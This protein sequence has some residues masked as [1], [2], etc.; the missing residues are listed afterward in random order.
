[1]K[2][3]RYALEALLLWLLFFVFRLMPV[4]SASALGGSIGRVIGPR[5]AASRK[6]SR[7]LQQCIPTLSPAEHD[8]VISG[9]WDNLG[10]VI[11]EYPH[12][13]T[14][15]RDY[16]LLENPEVLEGYL[17]TGKPVIY[18]G[19]HLANWEMNGTAPLMQLG[20]TT[21]LTYRE[22]NNP[23]TAKLLEKAR[24][25]DGRIRAYPKGA[26]SGR[27]ILQALK[28]NHSIGILIDQKYSEGIESQFFGY[29]AMTNPAFVSLSQKYKCPLV[30]V[31]VTRYNGCHF[32]LTAYPEIPVFDPEGKARPVEDIIADAHMI[33]EN[34][35][36]ECPEQWIWLH[37][38]WKS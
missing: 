8:V 28:D 5:L 10:R 6:A 25:L 21:D 26:E 12:L 13:A 17:A 31:R 33:L 3:I 7:H 35:I 27:K 1:M 15:G 11:A 22:P 24:T 19:G 37:R 2:S 30:P 34:W 16:T 9:M 38:R 18:I 20:R 4:E 29:P 14:L 36:K 23:W 32:K